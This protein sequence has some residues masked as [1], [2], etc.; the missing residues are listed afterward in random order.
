M[1]VA[2]DL[3]GERFGR[4]RVI[5][6]NGSSQHKKALWLCRCDCGTEVSVVSASL[7]SGLTESCGCLQRELAADRNTVHGGYHSQLYN[8]W[9]AMLARCANPSNKDFRY[10]GGK[11]VK[12][13]WE[14]FAAFREWA[15]ASG[16][17]PGLVIDRI[18]TD[19]HYEP[20]N[21]QWITPLENTA[22]RNAA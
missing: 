10:Y 12:V 21:C 4:L 5:R 13:V 2:I 3:T 20:G 19:G 17:R 22:R 6:R 1:A 8:S 16:Y 11:G 9:R 7:R 15:L 18:N 14:S